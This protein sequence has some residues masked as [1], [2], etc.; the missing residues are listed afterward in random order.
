M[1]NEE[2]K[3]KNTKNSKEE[4]KN[5]VDDIDLSNIDIDSMLNNDEGNK[6]STMKIGEV[7]SNVDALNKAAEIDDLNT[8]VDLVKYAFANNEDKPIILEKLLL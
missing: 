4:S 5:N 2:K 1:K 3:K 6:S 8:T 7:A